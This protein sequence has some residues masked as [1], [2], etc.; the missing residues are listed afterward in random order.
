[1]A[2]SLS[3]SVEPFDG[4]TCGTSFV[5]RA[6]PSNKLPIVASSAAIALAAAGL[7]GSLAP[8]A[9]AVAVVALLLAWLLGRRFIVREESLTAIQ[10]IG[11]RLCTRCASG[12]ETAQFIEVA[13]IS[14]IFLAEAVRFDRC[15]FYL[16]CLLHGGAEGDGC[17]GGEPRLVVPFRRLLPPLHMLERVCHGAHAVLWGTSPTHVSGGGA[18]APPTRARPDDAVPSSRTA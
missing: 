16:A 18:S 12:R 6:A 5:V 3:L 15:H 17:Q 1:M 4:D 13:A 9:V 8:Q 7:A 2:T 14:A 11:L 10:G